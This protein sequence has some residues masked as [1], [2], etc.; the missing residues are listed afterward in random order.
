MFINLGVSWLVSSPA[1]PNVEI[2]ATFEPQ[3]H[4]QEH[5]CHK[6]CHKSY[7][8][9][10]FHTFAP[11]EDRHFLLGFP[12]FLDTKWLQAWP[13]F[14]QKTIH[15]HGSGHAVGNETLRFQRCTSS[16]MFHG[17]TEE[18]KSS[19]NNSTTRRSAPAEIIHC[20]WLPCFTWH[21]APSTINLEMNSAKFSGSSA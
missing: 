2:M 1:L 10:F 7:L 9:F 16:I 21:P 17:M 11:Q 4:A 20:S 13:L 8:C 15:C 5:T 12:Q 6:G 18:T 3:L 14:W 19:W